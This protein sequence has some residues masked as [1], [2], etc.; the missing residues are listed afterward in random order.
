MLT[1]FEITERQPVLGGRSFGDVG[2]YEQLEGSA[3]FEVEPDHALNEPIVDLQF[4][5][6]NDAGRVACRADIWIL[7]PTDPARGN[8]NVLYHVVNRGRKGVLTTFNLASGSNRPAVEA[9][10]GDGF[11]MDA[12]YTVAACAW[13]ADVPPEAPDNPDL[14]TLDV[15]VARAADGPLTG[16]VGCEILVDERVEIHSLGS[17]YHRPY[18]VADGTEDEAQLTVRERP[19]GSAQPIVRDRWSFARLDDGRPA[20]RYPSGFEPGLIYNF[21]YTVSERSLS[22]SSSLLGVQ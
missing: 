22:A 9:E 12:G 7:K 8:G 6:R 10:F 5:P 15:P 14:M 20:I 3:W 21:V 2:A 19:Y 17:R 4:A 11:L 1:R 18:D 13:Q 16:P